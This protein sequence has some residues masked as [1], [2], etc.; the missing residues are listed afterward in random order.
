MYLDP[1][2][3]IAG[4][5]ALQVRDFLKP[6]Y[7]CHWTT[8]YLAQHLHLSDRDAENLILE[9]LRLG[10][11]EVAV[12]YS[13]QQHYQRTLAGS[14]FSLASAAQ[15]LTRKTAQKKLAEFLDRVR[16]ANANE[17]FVY[18]VQKV[19]VFGSYLSEQDHINDIDVAVELVFRDSDLNKRKAMIQTR[20]NQAYET[21]RQ[22]S[23][24]VDELEWPYKEVLLFLK[25]RSRAISLHTTD[26]AI[27]QQTP[28][29]TVFQDKSLEDVAQ[30][31]S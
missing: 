28:S 10:Y 19:V 18:C 24:F 7:N 1:K 2:S 15:P 6:L 29:C 13:D 9:L 22:F 16:A 14:T 5:S 21:G 31:G 11:I 20:I 23:S 25:S 26:D 17:D 8:R 12:E 30:R 3:L 4:I 27:L